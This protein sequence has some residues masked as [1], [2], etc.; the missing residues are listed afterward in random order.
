MAPGNSPQLRDNVSRVKASSPV[1]KLIFVGL[2]AADVFW[3]YNL[4]YRG[5]GI[6]LI[7]KLGG[8]AVQSSQVLNPLNTV[9]GL[10]PYYGLVALL[11]IGSSLKQI[12]HIIWVSEQAMDVGS[13]FTI[14]LFNTIFNTINTLLSL[15][16]LTSPAAASIQKSLLATLSSPVV[17]VGTTAYTVGLLAEATSEFQRKW[18]K[19]DPNNKGKPY[20][21]GLFSLATNINYGAYTTWRGA[22]ALVCGGIVWGASTFGFFFYDFATRGVPVLHEYMSQRVSITFESLVSMITNQN[23]IDSMVTRI[24]RSYLAFD[25]R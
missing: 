16:A 12:V 6:Q 15:W 22:Y 10:Q 19:Q 4:L 9:T 5:W 7:E 23:L 14:A 13:G 1:G 20:G 21:G 24:D 11:S 18:F 3:Q 17:A 25:T 8:H 2:R